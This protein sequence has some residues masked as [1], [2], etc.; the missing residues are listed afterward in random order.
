MDPIWDCILDKNP[1]FSNLRSKN[2][3]VDGRSFKSQKAFWIVFYSDFFA[4]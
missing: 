1:D 2:I 4:F 3:V